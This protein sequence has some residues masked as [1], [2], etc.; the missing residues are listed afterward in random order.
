MFTAKCTVG[1]NQNLA[2]PSGWATWTW[3]R[4]SS[5]EKK[6]RRNC[7][8]RTIVGAI[9]TLYLSVAFPQHNVRRQPHPLAGISCTPL[10]GVIVSNSWTAASTRMPNR[11]NL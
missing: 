6:N 9:A 8:S 10:F 11:N 4:G 2:P 7:P 3:T 5:R 1:L